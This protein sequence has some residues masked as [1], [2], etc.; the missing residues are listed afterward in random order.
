[1]E[2][3]FEKLILDNIDLEAYDIDTEGMDDKEKVKKLYRIFEDE[4]GHELRRYATAVAI[5]SWLQGLPT[6]LTLPF[7]YVDILH[8]ANQAGLVEKDNEE[9]EDKFIEGYWLNSAR[10]IIKLVEDSYV[11]N[12]RY[13]RKGYYNQRFNPDNNWITNYPTKRHDIYE[14][15]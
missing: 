6:V 5:S 10:A 12:E 2:E 3:F 8:R 11:L 4:H 1:M 13:P 9:Q 15:D 14:N 7:Y